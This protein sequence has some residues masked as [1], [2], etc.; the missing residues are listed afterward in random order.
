MSLFNYAPQ[1][2]RP[3][4]FFYYVRKYFRKK[5]HFLPRY[6]HLMYVSREKK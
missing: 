3:G 2:K 5:D 4:S 1:D 6:A